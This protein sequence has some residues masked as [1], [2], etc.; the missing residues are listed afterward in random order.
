MKATTLAMLAG[1]L[2]GCE[3][4]LRKPLEVISLETQAS[5]CNNQPLAVVY[6]TGYFIDCGSY[7][8]IHDE[9]ESCGEILTDE[10]PEIRQL[11]LNAGCDD[12]IDSWM[13]WGYSET[14]EDYI[15]V[16]EN[17]PAGALETS[18]YFRI[19]ENIGQK[20]V[21]QKWKEWL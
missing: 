8:F 14:N 7:H 9:S 5:A 15:F 10:T 12:V 1:C 18:A 19:L 11:W 4:E 17:R 20:A 16:D 6:E 21:E 2:L 13:L 3:Q